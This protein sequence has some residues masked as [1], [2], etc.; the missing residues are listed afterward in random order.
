MIEDAKRLETQTEEQDRQLL[1]DYGNGLVGREVFEAIKG[2]R[3]GEPEWDKLIKQA[4]E[5]SIETERGDKPL[6]K[7][8]ETRQDHPRRGLRWSGAEVVSFPAKKEEKPDLLDRPPTVTDPH[9]RRRPRPRCE[10]VVLCAG[11]R[12]LLS[13]PSE[14]NLNAVGMPRRIERQAGSEIRKRRIGTPSAFSISGWRA[15]ALK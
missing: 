8:P 13:S 9:R 14:E 1:K 2:L 7:N 15:Q 12:K 3:S 6:S 11:C 5:G 10:E 4:E